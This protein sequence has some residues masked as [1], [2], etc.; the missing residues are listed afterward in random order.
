MSEERHHPRGTGLLNLFT[1]WLRGEEIVAGLAVFP[2]A[3]LV[4]RILL[5]DRCGEDGCTALIVAVSDKQL[6][7]RIAD[8]R[9]RCHG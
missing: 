8:H 1:P 4:P 9:N 2:P 5:G 3:P 6:A 7:Q